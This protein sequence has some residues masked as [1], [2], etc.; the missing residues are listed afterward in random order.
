M[1]L[2]FSLLGQKVDEDVRLTLLTALAMVPTAQL[3][4]TILHE[5]LD[6]F[7]HRRSRDYLRTQLA[8]LAE[9]GAIRVEAAGSVQVATLLPAGRDHV[10]RR[11]FLAGV[12]VPRVE[13]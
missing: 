13:M 7:G 12:R 11:S 9:L 8:K 1:S 6:A 4:E 2:E 3:N 5:T 10:E